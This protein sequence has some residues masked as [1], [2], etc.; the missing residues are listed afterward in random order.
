M[1][2]YNTNTAVLLLQ[3]QQTALYVLGPIYAN[4]NANSQF[5]SHLWSWEVLKSK[6]DSDTSTCLICLLEL[7][8]FS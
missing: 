7:I 6:L 8:T 3:L 4:A 1:A 2:L 5:S